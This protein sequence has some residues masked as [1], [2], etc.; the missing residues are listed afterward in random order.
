MYEPTGENNGLVLLKKTPKME[1][2][3]STCLLQ[4]SQTYNQLK[5]YS[6]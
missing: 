6:L 3:S 1:F 4:A 5:S 2:K